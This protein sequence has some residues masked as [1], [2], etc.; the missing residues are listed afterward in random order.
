MNLVGG[1]S[2]QAALDAMGDE[3]DGELAELGG[4]PPGI[5][6]GSKEYFGYLYQLEEQGL[7]E[8][9]EEIV[10]VPQVVIEERIV[11]VPGKREIQE[12]LIE[13]PRVEWVE[14]VEYEDYIEYREVPVDKVI[15]VPEIEYKLKE[16]DYPIPQTYVQEFIVDK[17]KEVP[18]TEVQEVERIEHVPVMV[19]NGWKPPDMK[20]IGM[21]S[22]Q[23]RPAP[24]ASAPVSM[25]PVTVAPQGVPIF[26]A[27]QSQAGFQPSMGSTMPAS[28][29]QPVASMTSPYAS[30]DPGRLGLGPASTFTS[31]APT[32][33]QSSGPPASTMIGSQQFPRQQFSSMAPA[34]PFST[35]GPEYDIVTVGPD[36]SI[37]K[38]SPY[39]SGVQ[40]F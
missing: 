1:G 15:E 4:L 38:V 31:Q 17:Y 12:R 7:L 24:V 5:E 27:P 22:P 40:A 29:A 8:I 16:V 32:P 26:T 33:P 36:G 21:P 9:R 23:S 11:H 10:E 2:A 3:E 14:R 28:M 39:A 30:Y 6:P 35:A 25:P 34:N 13:V 19:P 37:M 20:A 18:V